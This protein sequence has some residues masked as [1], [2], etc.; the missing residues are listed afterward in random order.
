MAL[1]WFP[2]PSDPSMQFWLNLAGIVVPIGFGVAA[3][4]YRLLTRRRRG[5]RLAYQVVSDV[6]LVNDVKDLGEDIE[7]KLDGHT[8]NDARLKV[9]RIANV[10]AETITEDALH[11][12]QPIRIE[13]EP[14]GVIRCAIH[15]TEPP[16]L[17]AQ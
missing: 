3:A 7:V 5:K 14:P 2:S 16:N 1:A 9:V 13:F 11:N 6:R 15:S 12:R 4:L 8:V 17:I 10:G